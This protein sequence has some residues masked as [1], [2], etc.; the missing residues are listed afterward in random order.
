MEIENHLKSKCL[1]IGTH[2]ITM[3][4]KKKIIEYTWQ[5]KCMFILGKQPPKTPL[6]VKD[7][8]KLE[9]SD[10]NISTPKYIPPLD[11]TFRD[12]HMDPSGPMGDGY[13]GEFDSQMEPTFP[14][15]RLEPAFPFLRLEPTYPFLGPELTYPF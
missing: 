3:L 15:P 4:G 12:M 10:S 7:T 8:L 14:F 6:K 11:A 1:M 13:F 9:E 2:H 5:G